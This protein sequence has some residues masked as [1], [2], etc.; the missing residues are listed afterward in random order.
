MWLWFIYTY[1][2]C[3]CTQNVEEVTSTANKEELQ[4]IMERCKEKVNL[5]L[6]NNHM[7]GHRLPQEGGSLVCDTFIYAP[8]ILEYNS[9]M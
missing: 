1:M 7:T 4:W 5:L 6:H 2:S 3:F 8:Y 9:F